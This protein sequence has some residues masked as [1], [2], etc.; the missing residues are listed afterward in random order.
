MR[1][2]L[3]V[4]IFVLFVSNVAWGEDWKIYAV[5]E[6]GFYFYNPQSIRRVS[7]DTVRVWEKLVYTEKGGQQMIKG[8]VPKYI[9]LSYAIK[10][11]ELNCSEQKSHFL[12]LTYYDQNKEIVYSSVG[13]ASS[14]NFIVPESAGESIFNVIC[15]PREDHFRKLRYFGKV[16]LRLWT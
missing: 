13:Y 1:Q 9:K 2:I 12:S 14:W 11:I 4:I 16:F 8:T 5:T 15:N 3:L 6:F 10:L 7:K